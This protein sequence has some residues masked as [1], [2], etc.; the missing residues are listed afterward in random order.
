MGF[1]TAF[2]DRSAHTKACFNRYGLDQALSWHLALALFDLDP[3]AQTR[4]QVT[5]SGRLSRAVKDGE[6]TAKR[7]HEVASFTTLGFTAPGRQST[8][9]TALWYRQS[10]YQSASKTSSFG[11]SKSNL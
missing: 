10:R 8:I 5:V 3:L 7:G 1:G 9:D 4:V 11:S 2:G 6:A